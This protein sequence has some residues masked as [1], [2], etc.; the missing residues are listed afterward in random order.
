MPIGL[1]V[2]K[3]VGNRCNL[4]CRY[5]YVATDAEQIFMSKWIL[6]QT[7]KAIVTLDPLPIFFWGGGE[8]L[9]IGR[10]G[11]KKALD[12]Q[13]KYCDGRTFINSLQTNGILIDQAWVDFMKQH[14]FQVGVSWDGFVDT[15]RITIDGR[16]TKDEV[17]KNIE[18]C[19]EENLNLGIITVATRENINQL[20]EIAEFLYSKG[21]KNLLFKLYIGQELNLSLDSLEYAGIMCR[22]L[23]VWMKVGDNDWILE[24][25]RS[26]IAV[27]SSNAT[28]IACELV[29]GCGNF[30]TI[31][32]NGGIACCDFISQRFVFGN[33]CDSSI[34]EIINGPAYAQFLSKTK[35]KP[36]KCES[37]SW[38]FV[39]C[40]GGC[41]HYRKF[42]SDTGHWGKDVLCEAKKKFF[43]Y[44]KQR[45]FA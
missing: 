44:Y 32:H 31:E 45:Y 13:A 2:V 33:V 21:I 26:F 42:N 22:L 23:D 5:C 14:N 11:F 12:T 35:I 30:L 28:N 29:G 15:S 8:P 4:Q 40:G 37:C 1:I 34:E 24:P 39:C 41:L 36:S 20:P 16:L 17:W 3:A 27:M 25:I 10:R 18:L 9:L 19:L 6:E 38:Q 43:D 7:I